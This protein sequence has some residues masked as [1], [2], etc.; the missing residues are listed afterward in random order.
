MIAFDQMF[1][2]ATSFIFLILGLWGTG[3][4][5]GLVGGE[6][7]GGFYWNLRFQ[8]PL[9]WLEPP[10]V[11]LCIASLPKERIPNGICIPAL[12]D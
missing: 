7:V 3:F 10:L 12:F 6:F 11:V 4:A 8:S 5:Y 9:R 1:E 2:V